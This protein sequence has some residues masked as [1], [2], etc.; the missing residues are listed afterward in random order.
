M[1]LLLLH[2]YSLVLFSLSLAA[3]DGQNHAEPEK[4]ST[5]TRLKRN[6]ESRRPA[7]G[8]SGKEA[9]EELMLFCLLAQG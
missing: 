1:L 4:I 5:M 6:G 9:R 8:C 2:I 3:A 7:Y